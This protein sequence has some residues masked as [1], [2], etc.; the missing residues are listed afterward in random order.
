MRRTIFGA[1]LGLLGAVHGLQAD[2][3]VACNPATA[4]GYGMAAP[5]MPVGDGVPLS[6]EY[7]DRYVYGGYG[8]KL[9]GGYGRNGYAPVC[10]PLWGSA[11]FLPAAGRGYDPRPRGAYV[12]ALV[13]SPEMMV[14]AESVTSA[15]NVV[16]AK[17][18]PIAAGAYRR[19]STDRR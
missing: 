18:K 9:R 13:P 16:P 5:P 10:G 17:E 6:R 2:E 3:P 19:M 8:L 14:D 11:A 15:E 4:S 1:V 7:R 12:R